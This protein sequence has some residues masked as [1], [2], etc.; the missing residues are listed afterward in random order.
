MPNTDRRLNTSKRRNTGLVPPSGDETLQRN[1]LKFRA[2]LVLLESPY[3]S[4]AAAIASLKEK[5]RGKGIGA[6][7]SSIYNWRQRVL[8]LGFAG[9]HRQLRSDKGRLRTAD[10]LPLIVDAAARVKRYGDLAREFRKLEP[11]M[12]RESFRRW[13]RHL[14]Q[15]M[16]VIRTPLKE[17]D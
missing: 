8:L 5:L 13:I 17:A 9:L 2:V 1:L 12:S 3:G 15:R 7:G 14:Q 4:R 16:A 10:A 6:S 11:R